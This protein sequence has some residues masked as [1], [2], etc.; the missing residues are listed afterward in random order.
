MLFYDA[1]PFE[2]WWNMYLVRGGCDL[3]SIVFCMS[4]TFGVWNIL[5][6]WTEFHGEELWVWLFLALG[7]R[8]YMGGRC[9]GRLLVWLRPFGVPSCTFE[10]LC[11]T[12]PLRVL[13]GLIFGLYHCPLLLCLSKVKVAVPKV[14]R[15]PI[16]G[17]AYCYVSPADWASSNR[18]L[19][20]KDWPGRPCNA[21]GCPG[22]NGQTRVPP[23]FHSLPLHVSNH[24][25][26]KLDQIGMFSTILNHREWQPWQLA[27][28]DERPVPGQCHEIWCRQRHEQARGSG[29]ILGCIAT[30]V[31]RPISKNS[32]K[33]QSV[34]EL[35]L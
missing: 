9:P 2:M 32:G 14:P 4:L 29:C 12:S 28:H 20:E 5:L 24:F 21:R 16:S 31:L 8:S 22:V 18:E 19:L 25:Q 15:E 35:W 33:L 13:L 11:L 3:C 6:F 34:T 17:T 23:N 7:G 26:P 10:S 30:N 27:T 1:I